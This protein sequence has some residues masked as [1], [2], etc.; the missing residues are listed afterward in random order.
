MVGQSSPS[1]SRN[2]ANSGDR[3]SAIDQHIETPAIVHNT[4]TSTVV[5]VTNNFYI[6]YVPEA[7]ISPNPSSVVP[8][9]N[10]TD[11]LTRNYR[12]RSKE[13][14][15]IRSKIQDPYNN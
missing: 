6:G 14:S 4:K 15:N 13:E 3:S 11:S 8:K 1:I 5:P 9:P 10:R 12:K 2:T 7:Q